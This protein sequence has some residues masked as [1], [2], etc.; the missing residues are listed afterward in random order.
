MKKLI[1]IATIVLLALFAFNAQ[2]QI[3]NIDISKP[4]DLEKYI[5]SNGL[6]QDRLGFYHVELFNIP[7]IIRFEH[8]G[9]TSEAIIRYNPDKKYDYNEGKQTVTSLTNKIIKLFPPNVVLRTAYD[10]PI[11]GSCNGNSVILP[12]YPHIFSVYHDYSYSAKEGWI[13]IR[14]IY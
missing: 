10:V 14:V 11:F 3:P 9:I 13:W 5:I 12:E 7:A 6:E 4:N 1:Q 2:A 8:S